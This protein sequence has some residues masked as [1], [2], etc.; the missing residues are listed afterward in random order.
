VKT[1]GHDPRNIL[2]SVAD[3]ILLYDRQAQDAA[4]PT[5][6][7]AAAQH[8]NLADLNLGAPIAATTTANPTGTTAVK[9]IEEARDIKEDGYR[10][11]EAPRENV[12]P[13]AQPASTTPVTEAVKETESKPVAPAPVVAAT[14]TPVTAAVDNNAEKITATEKPAQAAQTAPAGVTSTGKNTTAAAAAPK[15]KKAGLFAACCG[16]GD[17]IE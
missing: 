5:A 10:V 17:H 7:A 8:T 14:S 6:H 3:H 16:K 12:V 1:P 2:L 15:K 4:H 9:P 11:E 13:A